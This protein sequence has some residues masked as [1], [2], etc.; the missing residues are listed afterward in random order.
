MVSL[1]VSGTK[2]GTLDENP[3]LLKQLI[4]AGQ[5]VE[6]RSDNGTELGIYL[7]KVAGDSAWEAGLTREEIDRKV[8][9]SKRLSMND[10]LKRLGVE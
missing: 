7:P 8:R 3:D 2:V 5:L 10:S 4:E 6:F 1:Y 9:E